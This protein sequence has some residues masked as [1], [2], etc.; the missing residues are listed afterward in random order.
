MCSIIA[1]IF[2]NSF[3]IDRRYDFTGT[4]IVVP[5]VGA[6][7]LPGVK[8]EPVSRHKQG[9]RDEGIT[10]LKAL[11]VRDLTYKIAFLACSVTATSLRV[12]FIYVFKGY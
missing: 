5:D 1:Y 6:L 10:G 4:L 9:D 3:D 8:S 12:I 11:G 2:N 7:A